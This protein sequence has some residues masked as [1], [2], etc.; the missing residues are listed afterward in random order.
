MKHISGKQFLYIFE[1]QFLYRMSILIK[2]ILAIMTCELLP[3]CTQLPSVCFE[4]YVWRGTIV[5]ESVLFALFLIGLFKLSSYA[6][7]RLQQINIKEN[8]LSFSPNNQHNP[9]LSPV[10]NVQS[11]TLQIWFDFVA[12]QQSFDDSNSVN[13]CSLRYFNQQY[14]QTVNF[15][16]HCNVFVDKI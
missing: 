2:Y 6:Q 12:F 13:H 15:G 7:Q 14:L 4:S 16:C 1:V 11:F 9:G 10:K 8:S 5:M 3:F